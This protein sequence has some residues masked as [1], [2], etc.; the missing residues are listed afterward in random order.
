MENNREYIYAVDGFELFTHVLGL[1]FRIV[2]ETVAI[3]MS[4]GLSYE[5]DHQD[6]NQ[7]PHCHINPLVDFNEV[8]VKTIVGLEVVLL[9]DVL[10]VTK[11]RL[12]GHIVILI[13]LFVVV[14]SVQAA[15]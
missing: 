9:H 4:E 10:F 3:S 11:R 6:Q 2:V 15:L 1:F 7:K 12:C 5:A 13:V 14:V 8:H